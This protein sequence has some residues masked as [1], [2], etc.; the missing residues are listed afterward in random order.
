LG[1]WSTNCTATHQSAAAA[2]GGHS[3]VRTCVDWMTA[4]LLAKQR[5]LCGQ[6]A[7][8]RQLERDVELLR[9][10]VTSC[11]ERYLSDDEL[12]DCR[13]FVHDKA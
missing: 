12:A 11:L 6:L 4:Q 1:P 10:R 7:V 8:A 3:Q 9:Q 5:Q 2:P 13:H